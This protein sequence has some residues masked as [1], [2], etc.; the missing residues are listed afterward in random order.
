MA[1]RATVHAGEGTAVFDLTP[2][3]RRFDVFYRNGPPSYMSVGLTALVVPPQA[4]AETVFRQPTWPMT[5]LVFDP[6]EGGATFFVDGKPALADFQGHS[7]YRERPG[8][9]LSSA[10]M[11][12]SRRGAIDFNLVM[13]TIR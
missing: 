3:S 4:A 10:V 5:E 6:R 8:L 13:L 9:T 1:V 11:D 7:Q 2:F 12:G